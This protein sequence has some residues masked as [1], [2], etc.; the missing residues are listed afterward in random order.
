MN[1]SALWSSIKIKKAHNTTHPPY[2][3][4][5]KIFTRE[6]KLMD[7]ILNFVMDQA[8]N[9]KSQK[10]TCVNSI[11]ASCSTYLLNSQKLDSELKYRLSFGE[12]EVV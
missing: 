10:K 5:L 8:L 7:R 2:F 4:L 12:F 6:I 1:L 11:Y 3:S 9:V